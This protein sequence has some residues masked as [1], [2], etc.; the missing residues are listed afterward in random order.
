MRRDKRLEIIKKIIL[1][2][3]ISSQDELSNELKIR[4]IYITQSTLSRDLKAL[5]VYKLPN[6]EGVY[7]YALPSESVQSTITRVRNK[8]IQL[9]GFLSLRFSH[10]LGIIKTLPGFAQ[11]I[12]YIIDR[13]NMYGI[14][15]SIAGDDTIML[16]LSEQ[17]THSDIKQ[18]FINTFP[19]LTQI[20]SDGE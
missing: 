18:L 14:L 17:V 11:S 20:I 7:K 1:E 9:V 4:N 8:N 3:S 12:A 16:I 10:N 5:Q 15:G 19:N 2:G 6:V 13:Q